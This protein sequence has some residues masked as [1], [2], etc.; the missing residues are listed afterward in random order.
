MLLNAFWHEANP[1]PRAAT[2]E[3][4]IKWHREHATVCGCRPIPAGVLRAIKARGRQAQPTK[5]VSQ[6]S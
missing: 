1:L 6:T 4:R 2:L 5:A 3:E